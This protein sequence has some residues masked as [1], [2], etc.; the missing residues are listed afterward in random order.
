MSR[1]S[2]LPQD[3]KSV[4][5]AL[6]PDKIFGLEGRELKAADWNVLVHFEALSAIG[7]HCGIA[8]KELRDGWIVNTG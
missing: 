7:V 4:S 1:K 6:T 8:S 2:S 5:V 3:A